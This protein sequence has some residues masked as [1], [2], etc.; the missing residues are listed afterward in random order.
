MMTE[1]CVFFSLIEA[2]VECKMKWPTLGKEA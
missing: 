1:G 2:A